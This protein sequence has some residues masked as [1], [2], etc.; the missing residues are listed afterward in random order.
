VKNSRVSAT[1]P[2]SYLPYKDFKKAES[3]LAL[4]VRAGF[5]TSV[6]QD[7][8]LLH[9]KEPVC[10]VW[11]ILAGI[12]CNIMYLIK[13]SFLCIAQSHKLASEGLTILKSAGPWQGAGPP[14]RR[15]GHQAGGRATEAGGRATRKEAGPRR[16]EAGP[17]GRR[18]SGG[19]T[20][21]ARPLRQEAHRR[22]PDPGC[23]N[24]GKGSGPRTSFRQYVFVVVYNQ[25]KT[26][27][28]EE[29][30]QCISVLKL[31]YLYWPAGVDPW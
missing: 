20:N 26:S 17:P 24:M 14:G 10:H 21:E 29:R 8:L 16:Q 25:L 1:L 15:Q 23:R 3:A 28:F 19:R 22:M 27:S 6:L 7:V 30:S 2:H 12:E 31:H 18:H 4:P 11:G 13:F 5:D 9:L